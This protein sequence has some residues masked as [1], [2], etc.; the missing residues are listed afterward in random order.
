MTLSKGKLKRIG[1]CQQWGCGAHGGEAAQPVSS[2]HC[3]SLA[4][5][6]RGVLYDFCWGDANKHLFAPDKALMADPSVP[7]KPSSVSSEFIG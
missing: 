2:L 5:A 7:P 4:I 6:V 3:S 1:G